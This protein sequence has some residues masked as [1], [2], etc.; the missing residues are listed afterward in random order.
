M[1]NANVKG[2]GAKRH[3]KKH[4]NNIH[5]V[6]KPA[7]RRIARRAGVKR[8]SGGIYEETRNVLKLFLEEIIKDAVTYTEHSRR[9]T[10][11]TMDVI[12][13]LKRHNRVLFGYGG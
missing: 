8:I 12:Y 4:R 11:T 3:G 6:T 13:A 7:I 1:T 2:S 10:C 5:G 9:K